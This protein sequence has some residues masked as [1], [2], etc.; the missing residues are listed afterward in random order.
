MIHAYD[1]S[2]AVLK[3]LQNGIKGIFN[4]GNYGTKNFYNVAAILNKLYRNEKKIKIIKNKLAI[5]SI[6]KLDVKITKAKKILNWKPNIS[7]RK[8]LALTAYKKIYVNFK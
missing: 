8:G 5:F 7:L 1:V 2:T 4:V 6:N 3:S